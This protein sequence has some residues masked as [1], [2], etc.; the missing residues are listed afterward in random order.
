MISCK[1]YA[2]HHNYTIN[3]EPE[4]L[5]TGDKSEGIKAKAFIRGFVPS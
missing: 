5:L 4:A 1:N 2:D 3:S